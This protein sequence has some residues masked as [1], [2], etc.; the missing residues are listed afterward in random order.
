MKETDLQEK[1]FI[2]N[3][4]DYLQKAE[5]QNRAFFTDFYNKDWMVQILKQNGVFIPEHMIAYFGGYKEAERQMMGIAP[6]PLEVWEWPMVCLKIEVKIGIGK[7]LTHRDYLGALLG[8]GIV[9]EAIGDIMLTAQGAYVILSTQIADYVSLHLTSIGRYQNLTITAISFEEIVPELP[10][11]KTVQLTVAS[12]RLDVI[13]AGGFSISRA[14]AAKLI[15]ADKAKC[16]GVT[17]SASYLV[18]E[19]DSVTLRGYG[20]LKVGPTLGMSKKEKLRITID[21]YI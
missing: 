13:L 9:R 17:V 10:N 12:L 19:G 11:I 18:K 5:K 8:L 14:T 6:Y 4:F 7:T 3:F 1:L 16:N 20:K 15:A 2:N 21:K